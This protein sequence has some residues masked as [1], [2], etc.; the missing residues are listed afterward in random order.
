PGSYSRR[1]GDWSCWICE[2][3]TPLTTPDI[4]PVFGRSSDAS[5][6]SRR[7]YGP[8]PAACAVFALARFDA[9]T[10]MRVRCADRP[11]ADTSIAVKKSVLIGY[12][13]DP[14]PAA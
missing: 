7:L 8:P 2:T 12:P 1:G 4:S 11:D 3:V 10:F 9:A 13:P 6:T 14:S 5:T